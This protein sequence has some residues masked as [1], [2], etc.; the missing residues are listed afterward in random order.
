MLSFPPAIAEASYALSDI[1]GALKWFDVD[2]ESVTADDV[3]STKV[4]V[5]LVANCAVG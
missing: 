1:V 4:A 5:V 3:G 2:G